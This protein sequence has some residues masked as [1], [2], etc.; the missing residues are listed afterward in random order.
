MKDSYLDRESL[1][2]FY[3]AQWLAV[4]S[5]FETI[6]KDQEAFMRLRE[7]F[8]TKMKANLELPLDELADR[9]NEFRSKWNLKEDEDV[10]TQA[11]RPRPDCQSR[12][13]NEF[14]DGMD[15]NISRE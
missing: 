12:Q 9:I 8:I 5:M 2:R 14:H 10:S 11:M 3:C 7:V 6:G 13:G 1:V 4:Y 15:Q